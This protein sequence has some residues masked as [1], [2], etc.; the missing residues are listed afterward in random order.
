M[1]SLLDEALN[2][3]K[4]GF[5][6]FPCRHK[7]AGKK[8]SQK[9]QKFIELKVKQPL[10]FKG[11]YDAT[12]DLKQIEIWWKRYPLAL[13][14]CNVGMSNRFVVDVDSHH[15]VDG[16]NNWHKLGISD[17]GCQ[18][19]LTANGGLHIYFSGQG[20]TSTN[21]KLGIDT[22]GKNSYTILP[23]S[24]LVDDE[25]IERK[26]IALDDLT[27]FEPK[28]VSEEL[29]EK[30]GLIRKINPN[31]GKYVSTLTVSEEL[32]RAKK[33][34]Y[35]L[36]HEYGLDYSRWISCGM[37]LRKFGE[38]GMNAWID[39]SIWSYKKAGKNADDRDSLEL[40]WFS[41]KDIDNEITIATLYHNY[42]ESKKFKF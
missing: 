25:G 37:A 30:L 9:E 4:H 3:A 18:K 13:I 34:L 38:D 8:F 14:G 33:V 23:N 10:V 16:M 20:R 22:R 26:Y 31:R 15:G 6:V 1:T 35:K 29:F 2:Y 17:V 21:K 19:V 27:L 39:W 7:S 32:E 36:P 24:I 40:K 28:P 12:I 5:Y 11:I 42:K 41:F